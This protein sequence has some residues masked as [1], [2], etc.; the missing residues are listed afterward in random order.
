METAKISWYVTHIK[1]YANVWLPQNWDASP[2][3]HNLIDFAKQPAQRTQKRHSCFMDQ[4]AQWLHEMLCIQKAMMFIDPSFRSNSCKKLE[5]NVDVDNLE[6]ESDL[7][8]HHFATIFGKMIVILCT[9][10]VKMEH[11]VALNFTH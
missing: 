6:I 2:G 4:V 3:E 7:V 9:I 5:S 11:N 10:N 1:R 8:G